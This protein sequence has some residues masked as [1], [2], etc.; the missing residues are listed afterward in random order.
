[1]N[2]KRDLVR[3]YLLLK[4]TEL[5]CTESRRSRY[6]QA[7]ALEWKTEGNMQPRGPRKGPLRSELWVPHL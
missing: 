2:E 6:N 7:V 3:L 4:L 1:M 5:K